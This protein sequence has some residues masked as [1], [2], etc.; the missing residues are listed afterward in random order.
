[1]LTKSS[2]VGCPSEGQEYIP[3]VPNCKRT[4]G[5]KQLQ[6][7]STQRGAPSVDRSLAAR[8]EDCTPLGESPANLTRAPAYVLR[9]GPST[10]PP[11]PALGS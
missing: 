7:Q 8:T 6:R 5:E 2:K 11:A 1:M 4:I 9:P 3:N 10:L